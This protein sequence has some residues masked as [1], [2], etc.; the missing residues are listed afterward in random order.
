MT[1]KQLIR[2]FK[3]LAEIRPRK[4]WVILTKS[5]IL[6]E[7]PKTRLF[8]FFPLFHYKLAFAPIISVLIII[9][10][11]GFAQNTVPGDFLFSVKKV[12]EDAQVSLSSPIEKPT[13]SLKLANKRLEDLSMIAENNQVRNLDPTIKE[14]Q[15]NIA[16]AA[17]DLTEIGANVTSSD[18]IILQEIVAESRKLEE[19]KEKVEAALGT[20]IGNT[21]ELTSALGVL[22][23]QTAAYLLADLSQRT[24][25]EENQELLTAARQDFEAGNYAGALEK[26]WFLSNN[27]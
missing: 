15:A 19:N 14:F 13:A 21:D 11:F 1:E 26:I 3:E 17:K 20:I 16:Q 2:H 6:A 18:P 5:Q 9:G 22:E 12:T 25:S 23:K 7:E 8:S 10:L 4:D 27:K 24:L